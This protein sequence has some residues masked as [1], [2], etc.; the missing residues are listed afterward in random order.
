MNKT[1]TDVQQELSNIE[2]Q[3][4]YLGRKRNR[5]WLNKEE[6]KRIGF[7]D[8]AIQDFL[9]EPDE[10]IT[11]RSSYY[12]K[13]VNCAYHKER[14]ANKMGSTKFIDWFEKRKQRK[15]VNIDIDFILVT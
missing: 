2:Q 12:G 6:L 10:Y 15:G 1:L 5:D 9:G 14:V 11:I 4:I 13:V 3:K 8:G 7:T